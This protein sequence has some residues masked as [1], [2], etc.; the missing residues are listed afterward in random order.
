MSQRRS[1]ISSLMMVWMLLLAGFL[2]YRQFTQNQS[3][4]VAKPP[5]SRTV[6]LHS[7]ILLELPQGHNF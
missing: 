3:P 4:N 5:T 1:V 6:W 2:G 7:L